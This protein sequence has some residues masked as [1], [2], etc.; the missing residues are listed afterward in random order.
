[1]FPSAIRFNIRTGLSYGFKSIGGGLVDVFTP[2]DLFQSG[3]QGAWY[4]PSDL[5]TLFQDAAGTTPVV[6]DGDPVG[7]ILDKSQGLSDLVVNGAFDTNVSS[8]TEENGNVTAE[9]DAGRIKVTNNGNGWV[10]QAISVEANKPMTLFFDFVSKQGSGR[11]YLGDSVGSDS[12]GSSIFEGAGFFN[13]T[14]TSGT[15]YISLGDDVGGAGTA[16][17]YDSFRIFA[18][19]HATQSTSSYRPTYKTDG[20]LH[21]LEFDGVDDNLLSITSSSVTKPFTFAAGVNPSTVSDSGVTAH[22]IL[23]RGDATFTRGAMGI[24]GSQ[25]SLSGDGVAISKGSTI[26]TGTSYSM[27]SV[28]KDSDANGYLNGTLDIDSTMDVSSGG[29]S[30]PISIGSTTDNQDRL[31]HGK[32]Y[33]LIV[34]VGDVGGSLGDLNNYIEDKSG[35]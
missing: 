29:A 23:S 14:P 22:R 20:T 13:V 8:W 16:N 6:S 2:L 3:E 32:I 12:Y 1:M 10:Y 19:N 11:V 30:T 15:V 7:L 21:Y 26:S 9:W 35:V 27:I 28:F 5:T 24:D 33:S 4:D 34:L 18:G 31:F 25:F 17:I